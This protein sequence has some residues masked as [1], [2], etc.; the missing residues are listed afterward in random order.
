[1]A[2]GKV[3][4][5]KYRFERNA[6]G[7]FHLVGGFLGKITGTT[8]S[9]IVGRSPWGTPFSAAAH[10]LGLFKEDISDLPAVKTGVVLEPV[11]LNYVRDQGVI[12]ACE[13]FGNPEDYNEYGQHVGEHRN[14]KMDWEDPIFGGHVD[15][16]TEDGRIVEVKTTSSPEEWLKGVPEHYWL[17]ASLYAHFLGATSIMFVVGFVDEVARANPWK[18][19]PENNVSVFNVELHPKLNEYLDF[20]TK[21]YHE[22]IEHFKTPVPDMSN[23][24]D[25]FIVRSLE[26]QLLTQEEMFKLVDEYADCE[27]KIAELDDVVKR[28]EELKSQIMIFL[29]KHDLKFITGTKRA[30]KRT[31]SVR[32]I[33][34]S[35]A[36]KHDGLYDKYTKESTSDS[37]RAT[38]M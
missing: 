29:Q 34:D 16:I 28:K 33:V 15:G 36:L 4:P 22:F 1:M 35:D 24:I 6:D 8:F 23:E 38:K 7:S 17:Q 3:I 37:F 30:Y 25:A 32:K 13:V 26:V 12:P 10:I 11:I 14:W 21:W 31:V 5:S 27:D 20:C 9:H 18:W 19:T 2:H